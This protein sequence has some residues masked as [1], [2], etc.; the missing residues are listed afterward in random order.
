MDVHVEG[1]VPLRFADGAPV[2]AASAIG[3]FGDGW[4]VAQDDGTHAAWL[5]EGVERP[6]QPV[7]LLPPV[8]GHDDFFEADGTKVLKPDLESAVHVSDGED[9]PWLLLLG[10]GS[11]PARTRAVLARAAGARAAVVAV[12]LAPLYDRVARVLRVERDLLNL[13][14]ACV[15]DDVLRWFHRGAPAA[16]VPTASVDV[17]LGSLLDALVDRR[18]VAAVDVRGRRAYGL[19]E[20][21]GVG[22]AVTDA[23][24]LGAG[25]VLV[26]AAAEDTAD[27]RDDGPVVGSALAV[28]DADGSVLDEV[29][30]PHLDGCVPKVEG[31]A[32]ERCDGQEARVLATLDAD[33]PTTPS[34]AVTLRVRW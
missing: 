27:P 10:S 1:V 5:R 7:R 8:E 21:R 3:R 6:A 4:L 26:S 2:R 24:A 17:G 12:E 15:V 33:D 9:G 25:R 31:M 32:L 20:V 14:G 11:S 19:G 29:A 16:G 30:L 23:V 18:P 34:L 28:I 22:L 13:E